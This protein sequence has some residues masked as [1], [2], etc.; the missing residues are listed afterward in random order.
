MKIKLFLIIIALPVVTLLG[1]SSGEIL[2]RIDKYRVPHEN[3]MA[4]TR[5]TTFQKDKQI[6][7]AVFDAYI[8][9]PEKS[10]VIQKEGKNRDMKILYHEDKLW[11]S[12]PGSR[13]PLRITPIQRL[14]GQ[15]SNG[16]VARVGWK[17]D[18]SAHKSG[19]EIV[20]GVSCF[21]LSLKALKRS[22][23]YAAIDL[24][25]RSSDYLPIKANFYLLSG[26]LIKRATYDSYKEY[27][28]NP[29]LQKMTIFDAVRKNA[30]TSFVYELIE[31]RTVP[32]KYF[33]KN[34]LVHVRGL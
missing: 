7:T 25:V 20:D 21:K 16:D 11:V 27:R 10:L 28:G 5:I 30:S 18:Y 32:G 9:G 24:W 23:T 1:Q 3:F 13:R 31:P 26:K 34:Y 15:A 2:E 12:L 8:S 29:L 22:S 19:D 4:R 14:I 6:D 17:S 33:N